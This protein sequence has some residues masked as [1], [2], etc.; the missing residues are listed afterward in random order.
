MAE[1]MNR[2][3]PEHVAIILDGNGRWAKK[4][5]LP[6]TAGHAAGSA[7]VEK[8]CRD[9]WDLG[10]KYLT[11]Y[12]FSTENWKRPDSEVKALMSL[13][14]R[15]LDDCMAKCNKN[16]MKVTI[17][18]DRTG[19]SDNLQD[20]IRRLEEMSRDNTG[21]HLMIALNYGGRDDIRR[22]VVE[23]AEEVKKGAL[24]PEEITEDTI[25]ERLDTAG[26]PD[27]DL[28]IR[29]SGEMRLSNY[30]IWQLSYS[31]FYF[32]DV[33]WPDFSK[34][35]LAEAIDYYKN[36]DRRFGGVK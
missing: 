3:G 18:G 5:H 14:G 9:A 34:K 29:T 21:L 1:D 36:R 8:I 25:S 16:N 7:N 35:D 20:Q 23:I 10:I 28:M 13:L 12:A 33:L 6:R 11:L 4:R 27:P 15:Y 17:I 2:K 19:L 22:A 26:V 30:L 31:E 24:D 32:T